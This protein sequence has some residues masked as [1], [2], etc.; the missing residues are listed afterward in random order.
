M[1]L[2]LFLIFVFCRSFPP[3]TQSSSNASFSCSSFSPVMSSRSNQVLDRLNIPHKSVTETY[4]RQDISN[5]PPSLSWGEYVKFCT[6]TIILV[7]L[8]VVQGLYP[9]NSHRCS[10]SSSHRPF[11]SSLL[12]H[13]LG[14]HRIFCLD[15]SI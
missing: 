6:L 11:V 8:L 12:A 14:P 9:T 13:P 1:R 7:L 15:F 10:L 5:V 3:I 2:L 4:H